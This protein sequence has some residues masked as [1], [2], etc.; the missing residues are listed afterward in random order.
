MWG[1]KNAASDKVCQVLACFN[2][3]NVKWCLFIYLGAVPEL[4]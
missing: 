1:I 4:Q 2:S 3:E